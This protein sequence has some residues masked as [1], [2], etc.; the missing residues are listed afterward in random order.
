MICRTVSIAAGALL[1]VVGSGAMAGATGTAKVWQH[2]G[3]EKTYRNISI[4]IARQE[5]ALT[6][7]DGLGTLVIG[8]AACMKQGALV[9][10]LPYD[11]TLFQNGQKRRIA[12]RSGSV[13]LNPT[14]SAQLLP[15]SSAQVQPHGVLI[16][17]SSKA[18][19]FFSLTGTVDEVQK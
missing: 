5:L 4:R 13:W 14:T 17:A 12:L 8:K 7:P 2:D 10:C 18:G 9:E 16:S 19:T 6:T 11:A 15:D 3:T 1:L